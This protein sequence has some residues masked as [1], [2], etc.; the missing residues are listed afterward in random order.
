M[1]TSLDVG[2][3]STARLTIPRGS[4]GDLQAEII[5]QPVINA[6]IEQG[7]VLGELSVRL[8]DDEVLVR[9]VV[10]LNGVQAAG[11]MSS[12]ID[13]VHLF[14]LETFSGDPLEV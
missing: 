10:A 8:G 11:W 4:R 6:P 2:I 3:E 9:P 12:M 7:Q 13:A 1:H 14:F 5:L